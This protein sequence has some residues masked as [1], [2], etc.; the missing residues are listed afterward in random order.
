[1]IKRLATRSTYSRVEFDPP[2]FGSGL[3]FAGK[4]QRECQMRDLVARFWESESG[5][6]AIEYGLIA[7]GISVAIVAIVYNVAEALVGTFEEIEERLT[8]AGGE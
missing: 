1:V 7:A 4:T 5:D 3:N 6:T 8:S 2:E